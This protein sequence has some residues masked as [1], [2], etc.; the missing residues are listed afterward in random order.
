[1]AYVRAMSNPYGE[2]KVEKHVQEIATR[3]EEARGYFNLPEETAATIKDGWLYTGDL[4]RIDEQGYV[5]ITGRK[6][7]I[8]VLTTG[9]KVVPALVEESVARS[10]LVAQSVLVGDE[11]KFVAALVWPNVSALRAELLRRG[12]PADGSPDDWSASAAVRKVVMESVATAC[13][14]LAEFE[15]PKTIALLPREMS[16]EDDELT[17]TLKVKRKVVAERW[18]LLIDSCFGA[19]E[20]NT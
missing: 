4:A 15:R 18:K 17:P 9:K 12:M 3:T 14:N 6:K 2:K 5:F 1:M 8:L 19:R 10:P 16:L 20:S 11:R 7:E 13:A